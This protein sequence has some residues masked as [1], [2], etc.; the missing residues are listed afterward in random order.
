MNFIKSIIYSGVSFLLTRCFSILAT[1]IVAREIDSD[2]LGVYTLIQS[3]LVVFQLLATFSMGNLLTKYIAG[4]SVLQERNILYS[5]SMK[6]V[7]ILGGGFTILFTGYLYIINIQENVSSV[8]YY[9][10]SLSILFSSAN[11]VFKGAY[12]GLEQYKNFAKKTVLVFLVYFPVF[13]FLIFS[14]GVNG[15]LLALV[16]LPI[17][18]FFIYG[19]GLNKSLTLK[20]ERRWSTSFKYAISKFGIPSFMSGLLI[21]P[22]MVITNYKLVTFTNLT[23]VAFFNIAMQWRNILL[24]IPSIAGS[25]FLALLSRVFDKDGEDIKSQFITKGT[26]IIVTISTIGGLI[27]A[28]GEELLGYY[29][30]NFVVYSNLFSIV[31]VSSVISAINIIIGQYLSAS[32]KMWSGLKINII[33]AVTFYSLVL[34][35]AD[36]KDIVYA[37]LY[38]YIIHTII[39]TI[40][41][42]ILLKGDKVVKN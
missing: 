2:V 23:E 12:R 33:W 32:D 21:L 30:V 27:I 9:G 24:I 42:F 10:S 29:N 8:L 28:F 26:G 17:I 41:V 22:V 15:A 40:Y 19:V 37:F 25:V 11:G 20:I 4:T 13:I 6:L 7:L 14:F 16:L 34:F 5:D 38:S 39:Q 18:E 36:L 35:S 3:N 31:I 1:V